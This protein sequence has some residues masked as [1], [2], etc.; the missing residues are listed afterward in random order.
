[1]DRSSLAGTAADPLSVHGKEGVNGS[2]PLE[3]L[4]DLQGF[5]GSASQIE[6]AES[7]FD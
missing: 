7:R 4:L 2:S 3:G 6:G 5:R 1:M